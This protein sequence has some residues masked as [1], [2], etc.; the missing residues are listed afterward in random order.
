M[1]HS[2]D[3]LLN[4][5]GG[6]LGSLSGFGCQVA[7]LIGHYG[8][9][10]ARSTG[11]SSLHGG[12]QSQDVGLESDVFDSLDNF[13]DLAG[14]TADILHGGDHFLHMSV[15][16]ADG[17]TSLIGKI[18]GLLG[19]FRVLLGLHSDIRQGGTELLHGA[20]LLRG[21]L[22][23][24]LGTGRDLLGPVGHLAAHAAHLRHHIVQTL[25]Q[26]DDGRFD[27]AQ[28]TGEMGAQGDGQ[29]TG[30]HLVQHIVDVTDNVGEGALA[31]TDRVRCDADLILA[32]IFA[33]DLQITLAHA[34]HD[35]LHRGQG[36]GDAAGDRDTKED[37]QNKPH[38]KEGDHQVAGGVGVLTGIRDDLLH[39]RPYA[40]RCLDGDAGHIVQSRGTLVQDPGN[41]P[42]RI[43]AEDLIYNLIGHIQPVLHGSYILIAVPISQIIA[44][45]DL[46]EQIKQVAAQLLNAGICLAAAG[47]VG[48]HLHIPDIPG[49]GVGGD[50][51]GLD[52]GDQ[53]YIF[54]NHLIKSAAGIL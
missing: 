4:E 16:S 11:P 14:G 48:V 26:I 9:A 25:K 44:G 24:S 28:V 8:E 42:F 31:G 15:A 22:S 5:T 40:G 52:I 39:F 20:G 41:G 29:I 1:I 10:L 17:N 54:I 35:F 43:P 21:A 51:G 37:Q 49:N 47:S 53:G 30:R 12:V 19:G 32:V 38:H 3:G 46:G 6:V 18:T 45:F 34:H 27:P 7:D 2:R 33:G 13:S 36:R 50:P 23:Q